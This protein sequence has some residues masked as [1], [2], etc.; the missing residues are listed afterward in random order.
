MIAQ[1]H[2]GVVRDARAEAVQLVGE[3][4]VSVIDPRFKNDLHF[5][6]LADESRAAAYAFR[7]GT[8][9]I[10]LGLARLTEY[11][12]EVAAALCESVENFVR[13]RDTALLSI[14]FGRLS[15]EWMRRAGFDPRDLELLRQRI[16]ARAAGRIDS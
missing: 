14:P 15:A 12:S 8:I 7:D 9:F 5:E 3:K 11:E 10:T 2:G 13:S 6:L 4:V 1:Q 16:A